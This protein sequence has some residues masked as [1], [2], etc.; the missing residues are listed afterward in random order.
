MVYAGIG[1]RNTPDDVLDAMRRLGAFLASN[2]C[3]LRSGGAQGADSAFEAGCDQEGGPKEIYLPFE[4]YN[5]NGSGLYDLENFDEAQ[6]IAAK[7]HSHWK[8]LSNK[9]QRLLGRNS[10]Q[11]LGRDLKTPAD[12]ILCYCVRPGGT[13]LALRIARDWGIAIY[14]LG[15][16]NAW[17]SENR[18]AIFDMLAEK[19]YLKTR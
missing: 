5:G 13:E 4:K 1:H 14:N 3:V 11:I 19:Y 12:F 17:P 10:Y 16:S 15:D 2:G 6:T 8:S 18:D 7:Y 9:V